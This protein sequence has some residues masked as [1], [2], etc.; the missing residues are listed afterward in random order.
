MKRSARWNHYRFYGACTY[1]NP[2]VEVAPGTECMLPHFVPVAVQPPSESAPI[3]VLLVDDDDQVRGFC[4]SLLTA[5]GFTVL[6]A[7]NGL[8]ALLTSVQRHGAIDLLLTDLVMPGI[9]GVELGRTFNQLWPGVNVMYMSGSPREAVA[10]PLP[11]DCVFLP[12]P[13]APDA[14]VRTVG[15]VLARDTR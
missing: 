3:T 6:E 15:S 12:K 10:D 2:F 8:E 14:L 7:H 1:M 13:F 11:A 9:N 5:N 4:R